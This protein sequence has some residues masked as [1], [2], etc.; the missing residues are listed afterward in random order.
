MAVTQDDLDAL[1]KAIASGTL[2]VK[3]ADKE[4]QYQ[5]TTEM[6]KAR[7]MLIDKLNS[8]KAPARTFANFKKGL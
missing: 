6:L 3:Y 7:A 4:V 2:R 8:N 1:E 5:S